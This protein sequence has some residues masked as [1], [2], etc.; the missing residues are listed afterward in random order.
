MTTTSSSTSGA[1][2]AAG[3]AS[4]LGV[5]MLVLAFLYMAIFAFSIFRLVYTLISN[6]SNRYSKSDAFE[7]FL[8]L[9]FFPIY[10]PFK[11]LFCLL[12]C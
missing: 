10:L 11:L 2:A 6:S 7:D 8:T 12:G 5:I 9:G 4:A 1:E 3:N